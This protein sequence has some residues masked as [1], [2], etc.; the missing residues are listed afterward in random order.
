MYQVHPEIRKGSPR[1]IYETWVGYQLE[2]FRRLSHCIS[3]TVQ[4]ETRV[5]ID[6]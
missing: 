6:H 2:I 4:D 1:S 5:A 3:E